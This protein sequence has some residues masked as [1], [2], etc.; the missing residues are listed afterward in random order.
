MII[1]RMFASAP[2][3]LLAYISVLLCI[4]LI[5]I[6]RAQAAEVTVCGVSYLTG[7]AIH[8]FHDDRGQAAQH[9]ETQKDYIEGIGGYTY[10]KYSKVGDCTKATG[11]SYSRV[12]A[13][14]GQQI[15][16]KTCVT[17]ASPYG[18]Y[19]ASPIIHNYTADCPVGTIWD[20][21][22]KTCT[23]PFDPGKN[24]QC[25]VS[26]GSLRVGAAVSSPWPLTPI[27]IES[28]VI[29]RPEWEWTV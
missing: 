3:R 13:R 19:Y 6:G 8:D 11:N 25:E 26:D 20:E 21:A 9:C 15:D 5:G 17:S 27:S 16:S 12:H 23:P 1:G 14:N 7:A 28:C 10:L 29:A 24:N 2:A 18:P 4:G 22:S